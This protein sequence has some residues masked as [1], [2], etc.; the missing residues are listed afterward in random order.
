MKILDITHRHGFHWGLLLLSLI[1][2]QSVM[3]NL[4]IEPTDIQ[5]KDLTLEQLQQAAD[6][7]DPDAQYAIGYMYYT[8]KNLPQNIATAK[9]WIKRAAVQ[10]QPQA[11]RALNSLD[12]GTSVT[13][14]H[15]KM[16]ILRISPKEEKSPSLPSSPQ[17][18]N[19]PSSYYT[20]QLLGS[21]NKKEL[22][23]YSKKY[24]LEGKAKYNSSKHQEKNWYVLHY[25]VYRTY[26][27]AKQAI[28]QL[29]AEIRVQKPWVKSINSMG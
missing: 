5:L 20:I 25:G 4:N 17:T 3:A 15:Q 14:I 13:S 28:M 7:G 24:H 29:P 2:F 19:V 10:G 23:E 27:E 11:M 16:E 21:S 6:A 22:M 12:G 9:N 18:F 1:F 26:N 8:G